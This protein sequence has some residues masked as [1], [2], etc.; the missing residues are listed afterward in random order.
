MREV[1]VW[2][3]SKAFSV[4]IARVNPS[5]N[6]PDKAHQAW[7]CVQH[8]GT[9]I[10]AHCTVHVWQGK[11]FGFCVQNKLDDLSFALHRL[12]EGC[13]HI[14][15]I[16]FKVES[17]VRL[18]YTACTSNLCSWNQLFTDKVTILD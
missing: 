15:A 7:I 13:S 14:A 17:A 2:I 9:V 3:V 10:T 18:G 4:L 5:Q 8:D 1:R 16:L 6:S 11:L 12:G